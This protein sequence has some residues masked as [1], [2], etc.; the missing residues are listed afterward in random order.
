MNGAK[1]MLTLNPK[2]SRHALWLL[3]LLCCGSLWAAVETYQYVT[4]ADDRS[5]KTLILAEAEPTDLT[6]MTVESINVED[7]DAEIERMDTAPVEPAPNDSAGDATTTGDGTTGDT[8]PSERMS[9]DEI[10]SEDVDRLDAPAPVVEETTTVVEEDNVELDKMLYGTS[11][12]DEIQRI[13]EAEQSADAPTRQ[14]LETE[15]R[16]L[17][18]QVLEINRDLFVL[19]EDLLFP[20]STQV[21]VFLSFDAKEYFGLDGVTLKMDDRA[22]SNHLYTD[23]ELE[24][25]E[26]GAVQRLYTGN[27]PTGKHELVAVVTGTGPEG[28]DF[29]RAV[30]LDFKKSEGTKYIE[31][32]ISGD[33]LRKQALFQLKEWEQ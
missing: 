11:D 23:R 15:M 4:Q 18:K 6:D 29:R 21:N 31:L 30:K 26:R 8:T 7:I 25:L 16:D 3:P 32:N 5:K 9:V 33:N 12:P 14:S 2:K 27:L 22:V 17:K 10:L 24:A 13:K 28:R 19:E 20:S 1:S